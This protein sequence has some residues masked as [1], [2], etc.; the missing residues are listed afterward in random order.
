MV[1]QTWPDSEV[2]RSIRYNTAS[3]VLQVDLK[4]VT[5]AYQHVDPQTATAFLLADSKG[6][7]FSQHVARRFPS[8]RLS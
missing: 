3:T 8:V 5:Y 4:G 6:R 2:V 1:M 7:F